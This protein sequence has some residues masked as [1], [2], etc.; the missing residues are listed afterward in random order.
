M[1]KIDF[2]VGV[3]ENVDQLGSQNRWWIP[4]SKMTTFILKM[5]YLSKI[6]EET[7]FCNKCFPRVV[8][9]AWR[10]DKQTDGNPCV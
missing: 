4:F 1:V 2:C 3:N 10:T 8:A 7:L 5:N 6:Q 9:W